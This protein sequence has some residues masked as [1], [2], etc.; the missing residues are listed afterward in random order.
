[1]TANLQR[2]SVE[3]VAQL[4]AVSRKNLGGILVGNTWY[5]VS[6]FRPLDLSAYQAG[7]VA[8]LVVS[9][10]RW[11]D[12]IEPA[13]VR[14]LDAYVSA[15]VDELPEPAEPVE[16]V[17]TAEAQLLACDRHD[18][19]ATEDALADAWDA[20]AELRRSEE[21]ERDAARAVPIEDLPDSPVRPD[22]VAASPLAERI[23][24][25]AAAL[26]AATSLLATH[27]ARTRTDPDPAVVLGVAETFAAWIVAEED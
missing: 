19:G 22:D 12:A 24:A 6:R 21:A 7:S 11:L 9:A 10:G 18:A 3:I 25:R 1:M 13:S 17:A 27:F 5:N 8:R 26:A 23:G 2:N 16:R 15:M 14:D 20:L 4:D